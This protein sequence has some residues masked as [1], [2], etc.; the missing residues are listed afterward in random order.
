MNEEFVNI[1]NNLGKNNIPF[2]F[3]IDF[4]CVKSLIIP[5][6]E[7]DRQTILFD[8]C[9]KSNYQQLGNEK[10]D[11]LVF[12]KFPIEYGKYKRRFDRA[13]ENILFGNSYL[14]N[15]TC[16]TT[17]NTNLSLKEIFFCS[18]AKYK[19][20][21][22][23]RFVVFS[24]ETFVRI[25][26]NRISSYPMKGTIDAAIENARQKIL[27]D[28]KELAEHNTIVDLIRNDLSM[29]AEK[30]RVEKFR[31]IEKLQTNNKD[32]LQ[33]SSKI[34]GKLPF[35][36]ESRIGSIMRQ[37]LPAGSISGAPKRKTVEI[38]REAE[39]Y[40]RGFYTGVMGYY[41][42]SRVDSAVM[43]RYIENDSG[44]MVFKSGGGITAQSDPKKEY[45][46]MID[47]VYVPFV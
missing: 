22:K 23:D 14:L 12:E 9:G 24:P 32:L 42:D 47:K 39:Q 13:Y 46:E 37:I 40:E 6:A 21:L 19:L 43:I 29:V 8:F 33:V 18:Q 3:I 4:H 15:L 41:E 11:N 34:S 31:Y 30:V 36:W 26:E 27:S 2:I 38:I 5:I 35:G 10:P 44:N 7:I 45:E 1:M 28:K 20:W 17:V 16:P 25:G